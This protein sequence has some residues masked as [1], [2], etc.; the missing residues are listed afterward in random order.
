MATFL[1]PRRATSGDND[2]PGPRGADQPAIG[3]HQSVPNWLDQ[4]TAVRAAGDM[5]VMTF[6]VS[7]W[8]CTPDGPPLRLLETLARHLANQDYAVVGYSLATGV[9]PLVPPGGEARTLRL[10]SGRMPE[11]V[12]PGLTDLLRAPDGKVALIIDHADHLLPAAPGS[13]ALSR[14]QQLALETVYSWGLD[15]AIRRNG[16]LVVLIS[17]QNDLHDLIRR[18]GS[19][20]RTIHVDLPDADQRRAYWHH[21]DSLRRGGRTDLGGLADDLGV[22]RLVELSGGLRLDDLLK[23]SLQSGA[24]GVPI[25]AAHLRA[26][27]SQAVREL[28]GDLIEVFEPDEGLDGVAGLHHVVDLLKEYQATGSLPPGMI[29]AGVPGTGK[30]FIAM[31]LACQ[32]GLTLLSLRNVRDRWVGATERNLE[33]VLWIVENLRPCIVRID[34]IDQVVPSRRGSGSSADGGTSE[35]TLGRLLEYMGDT[36]PRGVLWLATTNRPDLLDAALL[37]RFPVVVPF[38][39]PA[40]D[41]V[42]EL[43]PVLARQLGRDLAADVD[44]EEFASLPLLAATSARAMLELLGKA[45]RWTDL[46][47][48]R[49]GSPIDRAHLLEAVA[50]AKPN[51]DPMLN[52]FLALTAIELT[53]FQSQL[54]WRRRGGARSGKRLPPYLDDLVDSAGA[55]D[56]ARLTTRV[57]EL[58]DRLDR[59]STR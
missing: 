55:L 39:N 4:L 16:S 19:G 59:T 17:R 14:E 27:K 26:R 15:S 11:D 7:D 29:L 53:S 31:A 12:L 34:E 22:D 30:S 42:A 47:A 40:S 23:L 21:I 50:D 24:T 41:E 32:L 10:P 36:R 35:R 3:A 45:G 58:R 48:G 56:Q 13:A 18:G 25:G 49:A 6:N 37:E 46:D 57:R 43:L 1:R 38:I 8:S 28:G 51:A 54:P 9:E 44:P 52:E 5:A 20:Y 33:R 2:Q